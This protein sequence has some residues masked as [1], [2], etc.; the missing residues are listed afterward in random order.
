MSWLRC[1][2]D[3]ATVK[4][5]EIGAEVSGSTLRNGMLPCCRRISLFR[6]FVIGLE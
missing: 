5:L 1:R 6:R 4:L 3:D 2:T